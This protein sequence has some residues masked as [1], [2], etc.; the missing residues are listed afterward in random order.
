MSLWLWY[1]LVL[2]WILWSRVLICK[3]VTACSRYF[4]EQMDQS[5]E[6][7]WNLAYRILSAL[8]ELGIFI[9]VCRECRF[10]KV[11][12]IVVS[13]FPKQLTGSSFFIFTLDAPFEPLIRFSSSFYLRGL[14]LPVPLMC[15][16]FSK[17]VAHS[18][19]SPFP[20]NLSFIYFHLT[21]I[22]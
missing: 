13:L 5:V 14:R 21:S 9:I 10:R 2:P 1:Q 4:E 12:C 16:L 15:S 20:L 22:A 7:I 17:S 19:P 3:I 6:R 18:L 11:P 8:H